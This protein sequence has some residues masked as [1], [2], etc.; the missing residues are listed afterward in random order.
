MSARSYA[1]VVA[2][3][4]H[5][6]GS[7]WHRPYGVRIYEGRRGNRPSSLRAV[8][9][10]PHT[11]E[12]Y[13]E[14]QINDEPLTPQ[15]PSQVTPVALRD[16]QEPHVKGIVA[17]HAEGRPGYLGGFPT[18]SGKTYM[19]IAAVNEIRPR[20]VLVI[21]PRSYLSGWRQ[22]IARHATGPTEWVVI[23][24]DRLHTLFRTDADDPREMIDIPSDER[25]AYAI[26]NGHPI[27]DFDLVITDEAQ[28]L[29]NWGTNRTRLWRRLIGWQDDGS[30]PDA[31]TLNLS[32]TSWSLPRETA[33]AAHLLAHA[34]GVPVPSE[35]VIELGYMEWLRHR[36]GIDLVQRTK[37]VWEWADHE[38]Q[39]KELTDL[40]FTTGVGAVRTRQE[41]GIPD[42]VRRLHPIHLT[43]DELDL[44]NQAWRDYRAETGLS[45]SDEREPSTGREQAL[46]FRQKAARIKAPY[47]ADLAV[48]YLSDGY[49]V[50]VIGWFH[51]TLD[52][53]DDEI[54][55]AEELR[56]IPESPGGWRT[57][58]LSGLHA[59]GR[60]A[61][62]DEER[63]GLIRLF[64]S[65][66]AP[67]I[68]TSVVDAISLHAGQEYGGLPLP[69][70]TVLPASDAPRVTIFADLLQG[71]KRTFQAEGRAARD[72]NEADAI[73]VVAED[74][75]EVPAYATI[76]QKL[77]NTR[78][79][80]SES[81]ALLSDNDIQDLRRLVDEVNELAAPEEDQ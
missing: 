71:G 73:Y 22:V 23:N 36:I 59:D 41:L 45:L 3:D 4:A 58:V 24:P 8:A 62:S 2:G 74:T 54:H 9:P 67:I 35:Q 1:Y 18:G 33:S 12:H 42:Q 17:A 77:S 6:P 70:G 40:L 75:L 7:E 66:T 55:N 63:D 72:G 29:A 48:D 46:R 11:W 79:L 80:T 47:V 20:L 15:D 19:A 14:R 5:I 44:Y 16:Y 68:I 78:A 26:T 25:A 57:V 31:F 65:G 38:A 43:A 56:Q 60:G 13:L 76:F 69:D 27:A 30:N 81:S 50:V 34:R 61:F 52:K 37:G 64:Q 51:E 21:A 49:Q 10:E 53:L 32:A 39:V 28:V